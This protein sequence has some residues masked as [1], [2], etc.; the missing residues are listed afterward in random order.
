M[1][2]FLSMPGL[3]RSEK[4]PSSGLRSTTRRGNAP[5]HAGPVG[6]PSRL[7]GALGVVHA[8]PRVLSLSEGICLRL[9]VW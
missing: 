1:Y 8:E 6:G 5:V 7:V 4:L 2:S 3:D 9:T